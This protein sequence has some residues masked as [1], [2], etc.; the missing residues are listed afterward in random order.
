MHM[1]WTLLPLVYSLLCTHIIFS[2]FLLLLPSFCNKIL[3][4]YISAQYDIC[5]SILYV[6]NYVY[7]QFPYTDLLFTLF[8]A[9]GRPQFYYSEKEFL[10][11]P[12]RQKAFLNHSSNA[13]FSLYNKNHRLNRWFILPL[14]G[15]LLPAA[16]VSAL[17]ICQAL[18][19]F[20]C[21]LWWLFLFIYFF[22]HKRVNL[23]TETDLICHP[24]FLSLIIHVF[25]CVFTNCI[26]HQ[27]VLF[28]YLYFKFACLSKLGNFSLSNIQLFLTHCIWAIYQSVYVYNL[29]NIVPI[30]FLL[31]FFHIIV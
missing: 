23:L 6:I 27:N 12:Q 24:V 16:F 26:N 25:F 11:L 18:Y 3:F 13:W 15:G 17:K 10:L 31:L 29:E 8:L 5:N 2:I 1:I 30:S 28:P 14:E 20:N 4:F 9:V 7:P 22:T 19:F 21:R